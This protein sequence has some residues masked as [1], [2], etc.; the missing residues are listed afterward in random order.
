MLPSPEEGNRLRAEAG[1]HT[2][3]GEQRR[4]LAV[5]PI[6]AGAHRVNQ[7]VVG[8]ALLDEYGSAGGH[9][10]GLVGAAAVA[11]LHHPLE[12]VPPEP[13]TWTRTRRSGS[14]LPG[15]PGTGGR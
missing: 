5:K 1:V 9:F 11:V 12:L 3:Q 4:M 10:A 14:A 13:G 15:S 2:V 7:P 6:P 8:A